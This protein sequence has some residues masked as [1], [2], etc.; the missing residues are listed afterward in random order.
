MKLLFWF[1][2]QQYQNVKVCKSCALYNQT[3]NETVIWQC[4]IPSSDER[5]IAGGNVTGAGDVPKIWPRVLARGAAL[6]EQLLRPLREY[7]H[8]NGAV[9]VAVAMHISPEHKRAHTQMQ[10]LL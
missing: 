2:K 3:R 1:K 9:V 7:P 6:Q 10:T 8:V 5:R 4:R